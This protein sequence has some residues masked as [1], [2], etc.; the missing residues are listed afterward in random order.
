MKDLTKDKD[1]I[2]FRPTIK[3]YM[4]ERLDFNATFKYL[5]SLHR[6]KWAE[7][8]TERVNINSIRK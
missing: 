6:S 7:E 2:Y 8:V 5:R 3:T 4:P 1:S